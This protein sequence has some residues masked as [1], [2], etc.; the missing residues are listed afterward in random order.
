MRIFKYFIPLAL[1]V[2]F[3]SVSSC[4]QAQE[5]PASTQNEAHGEIHWLTFE[6]ALEKNK[7][8]PKKILI[9]FYTDWCGWCKRMDKATYE[10]AA[11]AAYINEHFYAIKFDAEQKDPIT[12]NGREFTNRGPQPG[13]RRKKGTHDLAIA[14][15]NGKMSYPTTLFMNE[16]LEI[17]TPIPGFKDAKGFEPIMKFM[18]E[19]NGFTQ[20]DWNSYMANFQSSL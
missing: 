18:I 7:K 13:A 17:I 5:K 15:L 3:I 10:N 20:D 14:L 19:G 11:I 4:V 6:E 8:E 16:N 12:F 1:L 2:G 9:D